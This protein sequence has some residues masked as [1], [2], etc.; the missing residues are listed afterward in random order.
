[1]ITTMEEVKHEKKIKRGTV[2]LLIAD[3]WRFL[4]TNKEVTGLSREKRDK[5]IKK[6]QKDILSAYD[7]LA[8]KPEGGNMLI[9][10][11]V[12][13]ISSFGNNLFPEET[14]KRLLV[15]R[16]N[17]LIPPAGEQKEYLDASRWFIWGI[18]DRNWKFNL[19]EDETYFD[20]CFY[21]DANDPLKVAKEMVKRFSNEGDT[22]LVLNDYAGSVLKEAIESEGRVYISGV[23]GK[24]G[25]IV[26]A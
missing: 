17:M 14:I 11:D 22:V 21:S 20:S 5:Y 7:C 4:N 13:S 3:P 18:R 9:G 23:R 10:A 12:F 6:V 1:M 19:L 16:R 15:W 25:V 2:N 26:Y 8:A 24:N